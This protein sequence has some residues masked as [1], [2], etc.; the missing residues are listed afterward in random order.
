MAFLISEEIPLFKGKY[1]CYY[2]VVLKTMLRNVN[3]F[4][5]KY[6]IASG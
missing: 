5:R 3:I 2:N 4:R 1:M 6:R